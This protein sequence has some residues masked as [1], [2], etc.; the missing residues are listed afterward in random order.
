[1][2]CFISSS[3]SSG[4]ENQCSAAPK[5]LAI[6]NQ[7]NM[8]SNDISISFSDDH[9]AVALPD[10][11][12]TNGLDLATQN[13]HSSVAADAIPLGIASTI[14]ATTTSLSMTTSNNQLATNHAAAT[15]SRFQVQPTDAAVLQSYIRSQNTTV[16]SNTNYMTSSSTPEYQNSTAVQP[17]QPIRILTRKTNSD[18]NMGKVSAPHGVGVRRVNSDSTTPSRPHV[19]ANGAPN[20]AEMKK[21]V[22]FPDGQALIK[23]F[24]H[25]PNPWY[26]GK[27]N[28]S[29]IGYV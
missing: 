9:L 22:S 10:T 25:A 1:M 23:G 13:M 26:N 16:H 11:Q 20:S 14:S 17:T 3:Y 7:R 29:F 12:L 24:A 5:D 18:S 15:N 19:A 6:L 28:F 2:L 21:R 4:S 8:S 27:K